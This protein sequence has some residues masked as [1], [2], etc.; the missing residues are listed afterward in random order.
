MIHTGK[1]T[2]IEI[3]KSEDPIPLLSI[4]IEA[5]IHW[6]ETYIVHKF[7]YK[8]R[9]HL[10]YNLFAAI[11][12]SLLKDGNFDELTDIEGTPIEVDIEAEE[13]TNALIVGRWRV[14]LPGLAP[15][16]W[17][18]NMI[19]PVKTVEAISELTGA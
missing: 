12:E 16:M 2:D 13:G 1:I 10:H 18:T 7:I 19:T 15:G 6:G 5:D 17:R 4:T 8:V 14:M 9:T 11:L 3:G